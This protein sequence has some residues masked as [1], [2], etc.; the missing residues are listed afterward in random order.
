MT[1]PTTAALRPRLVVADAAAAIDWYRNVFGADE[2]ARY[3]H[4]AR[5]VHA[6]VAVGTAHWTLKD[7]DEVDRAP[8][9][10][11][12]YPVLLS[13][14]I[15]QVDAVA[16]RM[17]AGGAVVIYPVDDY[18]YGRGGRLRDPFGHVWMVAEAV[19]PSSA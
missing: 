15:E 18:E 6:E 4:D 5:I 13:L 2:V 14:D 9:S 16:D 19:P 11:G 7:E 10:A 1:T 17:I 3:T 8:T 12:G